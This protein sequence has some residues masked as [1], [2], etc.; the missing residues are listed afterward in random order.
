VVLISDDVTVGVGDTTLLICV[1]YS[2]DDEEIAWTLNGTS[3]TNSSFV[4]IHE[5]DGVHGVLV[6]KYSFLELC[7][8]AESDAGGYACAVSDSNGTVSAMTQL[9]VTGKCL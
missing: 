6:F 4:S 8:V 3:V 1:T 2:E 7:S 9:T 5:E